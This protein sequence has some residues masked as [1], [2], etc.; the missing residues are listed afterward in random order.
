MS[1]PDLELFASALQSIAT[2]STAAANLIKDATNASEEASIDYSNGISLLGLKNSLMLEYMHNFIILTLTR[3]YGQSISN[4]NEA[5]EDSANPS[6]LVETLVKD[7]IILEKIRPLEAKLK[8][9]VDKLVKKAQQQPGSDS[10]STDAGA[11]AATGSGK[12]SGPVIERF[13]GTGA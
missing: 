10:A 9:Q 1:L 6:K 5:S 7:R 13:N 11:A 2:S 12:K 4:A 3:L 8:Y